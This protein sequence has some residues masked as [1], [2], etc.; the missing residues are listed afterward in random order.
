MASRIRGF[1]PSRL[2]YLHTRCRTRTN[3]Y[4]RTVKSWRRGGEEKGGASRKRV[5]SH[6]WICELSTDTDHESRG[7]NSF[8]E[9]LSDSIDYRIVGIS[10]PK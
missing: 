4:G 9:H 6:L 10:G 1:Y 3:A 7:W 8:V 5:I 2:C